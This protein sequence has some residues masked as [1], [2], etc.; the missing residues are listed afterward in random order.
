MT[1]GRPGS[2][3]VY[4]GLDLVGDGL[5]KL[6]FVRALRG[7]FPDAR[8]T[9]LAGKGASVYAG[10][11]APLVAGLID[12]VIENAGIGSRWAELV[13]PRPL[14]GRRF[15][16]VID[17]QR[18]VLTSLVLRRIGHGTFLSAALDWHLSDARPRA[19]AKPP[20][21]L[22]Q[23]LR[24]AELAGPVESSRQAPIRL[25][26]AIEARAARLLP[27]GQVYVGLAP[28]A[29]GRHK[30]WPL[31]RFADLARQIGQAGW[32]PVMLLGP[33]EADW[34]DELRR[35]VPS[36]LFPLQ[37]QGIGSVADTIAIARGLTLAVA[38]DSGLGH[39]LAAADIPLISLFGPTP[40][41]KFAPSARVLRIVRA[42]DFGGPEME[43]IPL[44]AVWTEVNMLKS[45]A[46]L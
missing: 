9:W 34:V 46:A 14:G 15:D 8:I 25:D 18:R 20:G 16:L 19:R 6:P 2:I 28:G 21:M 31:D 11:L 45:I 32:I 26:V 40:A 23:M 43:R 30:C 1:S 12:E 10:A 13:G 4:V 24:L 37:E 7:A 39:M 38:N 33:A 41:E 35:R 17:T 22:A 27:S 36:A 5:M 42:Q 29:G 3:L 44:E